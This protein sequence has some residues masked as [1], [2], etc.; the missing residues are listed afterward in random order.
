MLRSLAYEAAGLAANASLP[1]ILPSPASPQAEIAN[2]QKEKAR[3]ATTTI[4]DEL[5]ADPELAKVGRS[6]AWAACCTAP[7][8][9]GLCSVG[10]HCWWQAGSQPRSCRCAE[11]R[12]RGPLPGECTAGG[13]HPELRGGGCRPAPTH[14]HTH[15]VPSATQLQEVDEAVQKN[16]FMV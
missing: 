2:I 4:D 1:V 5:A 14:S 11:H 13:C 9:G 15:T 8:A 16:Y 3:I 12:S 6:G 7:A 10:V